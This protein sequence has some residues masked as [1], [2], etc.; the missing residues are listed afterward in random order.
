MRVLC[1]LFLFFCSGIATKLFA[2]QVTIKAEN[3]PIES[4]F[5]QIKD[6]TNYTFVFTS[7]LLSKAVPVNM[8]VSNVPL[9]NALSQ[10]FSNQPLGYTIYN[11]AII[12]KEK[13][14]NKAANTPAYVQ[15]YSVTGVIN[16]EKG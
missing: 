6:Q 16:D 15:I 4:V 5:R 10:L 11:N 7:E 2:Q 14:E 9:S 3:A 8:N 1:L 12:I 13:P